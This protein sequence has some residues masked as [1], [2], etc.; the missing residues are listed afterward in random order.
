MAA[1]G[2]LTSSWPARAAGVPHPVVRARRLA[3][4]KEKGVAETD[5]GVRSSAGE[6][7]SDV[8]ID[9][10]MRRELVGGAEMQNLAGAASL[11]EIAGVFDEGVPGFS[12]LAVE[13]EGRLA[14]EVVLTGE[15]GPV[16]G[17]L[18]ASRPI[19]GERAGPWE[20]ETRVKTMTRNLLCAG[21]EAQ[22]EDG[23]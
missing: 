8:K 2:N 11:R 13:E 22:K 23:G 3:A 4:E 14:R 1:P 18:A 17:H 19:L 15:S 9:L 6:A 12:E 16:E 10:V 21:G 7:D 20:L 5:E